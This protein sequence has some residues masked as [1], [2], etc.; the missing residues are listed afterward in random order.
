MRIHIKISSALILFLVIAASCA[1]KVK[2]PQETAAY[3]EKYRP[4][5]HFSPKANWMNDPNGMVFYNGEYHLF[6]QH[7]PNGL[8]WGPMHWGHTVSKDL[9]HWENLPIA[10]Y[11]D[12][13]GLIFSG[14]VV[15]DHKNTSEFGADNKPP[16]VAIFTYHSMEKEKA[17]ATDY[18]S[19]GIAFS[20]DNGRSWKKYE[21]NPVIKNQG[22]K[23]FR[24]PKV[25][26]HDETNKWVM[27]LA[28]KDHVEL[29]ASENLKSWKKLS[30][31]GFEYGAHG[32]VWECPDLFQLPVEG[33]VTRKWTLVVSINPGGPNGGSA[34]QYF[35]GEF[36]GT[37]F[38]P[39]LDKSVTSWLDYGPDN[40]A[41]VTWSNVSDG[42]KI[43]LGWMSNWAYAQDVPTSPWR[44]AMT[45][46]RD[47]VL[48][49]VNDRLFV[50]SRL[51]PELL[52]HGV[53]AT[54]PSSFT[55][56][57]S[58][59]LN[60]ESEDLSK[61][62]VRFT[63]EAKDFSI[64][65]SNQL[66]EK[67]VVGFDAAKNA[68]FINRAKSGNVNFSNNFPLTLSSPRIAQEGTI[69]VTIFADEA[70][71]EVFCDDGLS[72]MTSVIFPSEPL[73]NWTVKG[74]A[75]KVSDVDVRLMKSIW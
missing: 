24:D 6:Y 68:F 30:D 66:G 14:S 11:P 61:S 59:N 10:L 18:Q 17:G 25:F 40:Y 27:I 54:V 64:E 42:R 38:K 41:G 32:G 26:W 56:V 43:F 28:V 7:Y 55:V 12:S 70:S 72:V 44:S 34:T 3:H 4:Q 60:R 21:H 8:K 71:L 63:V 33:D 19:Q 2:V 65:L 67:A 37:T 74:N 50:K 23:D 20:V 51:S 13:V 16:L 48:T 35:T 52:S 22:V 58:F 5:L 57:D 73:R 46:P 62:I 15:V 45:A 9:V 29:W 75:V 1:R 39:D 36:D 47:L 53:P 49:K 31:F 69:Q